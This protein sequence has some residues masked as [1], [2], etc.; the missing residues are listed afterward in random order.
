MISGKNG[1][2][3]RIR[4]YPEIQEKREIRCNAGRPLR[5]IHRCY[6]GGISMLCFYMIV[7]VFYMILYG[8]YMILHVFYMILFP[9]QR[10]QPREGFLLSFYRI[11]F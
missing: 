5:G 8:F 7:Y 10:L 2:S 6:W 3:Q 11:T 4:G 1:T 9:K